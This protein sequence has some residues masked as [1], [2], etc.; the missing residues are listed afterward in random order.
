M[1]ES[2]SF[3]SLKFP[4][5]VSLCAQPKLQARGKRSGYCGDC[6][7]HY[8][9]N[10]SIFPRWFVLQRISC[11]LWLFLYWDVELWLRFSCVYFLLS[12]ISQY[13]SL[14][15]TETN[16]NWFQWERNL[17]K[18]YWG[19]HRHAWRSEELAQNNTVNPS[20]D[21]RKKRDSLVTCPKGQTLWP[22]HLHWCLGSQDVPPPVST[23]LSHYP[24]VQCGRSVSESLKF[25]QVHKPYLQRQLGECGS[26]I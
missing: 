2:T 7:A 9:F 21:K 1:I 12:R 25:S 14:S 6:W 8:L 13:T 26:G 23:S 4:T 18:G 19:T 20:T 10:K 22:Y 3:L 15:A 17:S 5:V 24:Q 16:S 11:F